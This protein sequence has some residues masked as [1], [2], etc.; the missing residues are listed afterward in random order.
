MEIYSAFFSLFPDA[1]AEQK[2]AK[3]EREDGRWILA[4]QA[5]KAM[6]MEVSRH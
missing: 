3:R 5:S 1:K 4:R 2:E 6:T